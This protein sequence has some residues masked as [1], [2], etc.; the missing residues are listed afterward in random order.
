[1][2]WSDR[3]AGTL[4]KRLFSKSHIEKVVDGDQRALEAVAVYFEQSRK[5]F[6]QKYS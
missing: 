4:W 5:S 6:E 3:I 1:M 2:I